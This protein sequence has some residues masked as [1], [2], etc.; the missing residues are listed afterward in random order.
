MCKVLFSKTERGEQLPRK[1]S[2]NKIEWREITPN[3]KTKIRKGFS[4][5]KFYQS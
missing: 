1:K 4:K 3:I 2:K 5:E